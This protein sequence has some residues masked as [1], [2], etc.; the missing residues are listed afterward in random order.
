MAGKK[1]RFPC[2][3]CPGCVTQ[4]R[5]DLVRAPAH[6]W[7][8]SQDSVRGEVACSGWSGPGVTWSPQRL[9]CCLQVW[10]R[11]GPGL[12]RAGGPAHLVPPGGPAQALEGCGPQSAWAQD[13]A[14]SRPQSEWGWGH[15]L[16]CP[17]G[18]RT[19]VSLTTPSPGAAPQTADQRDGM[20][21]AERAAPC[22]A[23]SGPSLAQAC[24]VWRCHPGFKQGDPQPLQAAVWSK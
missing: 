7:G 23:D 1:G 4:V 2:W 11:P 12:Q 9:C 3:I 5:L 13:S 6:L 24:Q 17:W 8:S 21:Q 22:P 10:A 14:H 20:S 19:P 16:T 15:Q 18:T